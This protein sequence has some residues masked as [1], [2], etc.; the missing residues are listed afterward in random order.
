MA[1]SQSYWGTHCGEGTLENL[2][3]LSAESQSEVQE[4][5][6]LK[7][8]RHPRK[9]K[10]ESGSQTVY[11]ET[12]T[13]S[14]TPDNDQGAELRQELQP[15]AKL[16]GQSARKAPTQTKDAARIRENRNRGSTS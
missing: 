2:I 1:L 7:G 16:A 14:G 12:R 9:E 15:W 8:V 13:D 6:T 4:R 11:S 10:P 5:G 3:V